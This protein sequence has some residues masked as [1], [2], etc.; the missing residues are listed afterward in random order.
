[1][2]SADYCDNLIAIVGLSLSTTYVL[3]CRTS[4]CKRTNRQSRSSL[5]SY[6]CLGGH[7]GEAPGTLVDR[8][9]YKGQLLSL[10]CM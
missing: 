6:P 9:N 4:G 8:A 10:I 5:Q 7:L 2:F 1:M 3:T